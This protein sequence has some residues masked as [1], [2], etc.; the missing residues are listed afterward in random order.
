MYASSTINWIHK[1][2]LICIAYLRFIVR[3]RDKKSVK[4]ENQVQVLYS[5]SLFMCSS[6]RI[7]CHDVFCHFKLRLNHI[8]MVSFKLEQVSWLPCKSSYIITDCYF[9]LY[10]LG[11][12]YRNE[13]CNVRPRYCN[14][15]GKIFIMVPRTIFGI[16]CAFV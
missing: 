10:K 1:Y 9:V 16:I 3:R 4:G 8:N 11:S 15:F 14:H 5:M 13:L 6:F 7:C 2:Y 12:L